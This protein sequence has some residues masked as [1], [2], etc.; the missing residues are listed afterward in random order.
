MK[1]LNLTKNAYNLPGGETLLPS[2]KL[3]VLEEKKYDYQ[4]IGTMGIYNGVFNFEPPYNNS[5]LE[6]TVPLF[7][8]NKEVCGLPEEDNEV[9]IIVDEEILNHIKKMDMFRSDLISPMMSGPQFFALGRF[10]GVSHYAIPG[11]IW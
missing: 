11:F 7:K 10:Q 3:A 4:Q 1:I 8:R 6:K 9:T 2:G 5:P